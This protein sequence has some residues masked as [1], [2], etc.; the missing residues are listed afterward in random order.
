MPDRADD[1]GG[2]RHC[3]EMHITHTQKAR[4]PLSRQRRRVHPARVE[5]TEMSKTVDDTE[6]WVA[7]I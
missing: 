4:V 1:N 7:G 6:P 5:D 2:D 3:P